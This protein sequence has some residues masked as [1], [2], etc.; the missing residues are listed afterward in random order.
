MVVDVAT[1]WLPL[2]LEQ[3][4]STLCAQIRGFGGHRSVFL[5]PDDRLW[6]AEPDEELE[7]EGYRYVGTFL[8]PTVDELLGALARC[9]P[10]LAVQAPDAHAGVAA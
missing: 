9:L 10:R 1:S 3:A 7:D 5:D 6:H 4:A 2:G 8:R